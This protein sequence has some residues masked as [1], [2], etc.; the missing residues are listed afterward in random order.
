MR[1]ADCECGTGWT[2]QSNI[3]DDCPACG[4]TAHFDDRESLVERVARA[5]YYWPTQDGKPAIDSW[6]AWDGLSKTSKAPWIGDAERAI[7][8][9]GDG[10]SVYAE[11]VRVRRALQAAVDAYGKPGGPWNVPS[12]PGAW[13]EQARVALRMEA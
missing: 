8:A 6:D 10:G 5:I 2:S 13:I 3:M 12:D 7:A 1:D 11:L 9:M 4:K